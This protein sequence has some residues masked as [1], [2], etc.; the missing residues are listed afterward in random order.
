M[1]KSG[2]SSE[3]NLF[4][5]ITKEKHDGVLYMNTKMQRRN[6]NGKGGQPKNGRG[7]GNHA[8]KVNGQLPQHAKSSLYKTGMF[9]FLIF[10]II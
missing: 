10:Q 2:R 4:L 9:C 1:D 3:S 6:N 5:I 7:G 8:K